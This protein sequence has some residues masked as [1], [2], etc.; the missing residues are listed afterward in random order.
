MLSEIEN[1]IETTKR[2]LRSMGYLVKEISVQEFYDY[3]TGEIFSEDATTLE[4]V[5][6]D[7]YLLVHGLVEINE[8][9]NWGEPLT[10]L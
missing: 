2:A 1:R 10:N 6:G 8:L 9:K 5:L 7:E 3:M 4:D